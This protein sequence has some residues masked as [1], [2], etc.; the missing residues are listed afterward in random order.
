MPLA[1][2]LVGAA[3]LV[4][5]WAHGRML[6]LDEEMIA[7]NLRDRTVTTLT[8]RLSLGQAA[9]YGWLVAQ[10]AMLLA[11][12]S[13]ERALRFLPMAFGV[14]TL[15]AALWIGRR[16]MR[17]GGAA[18]LAFLCA[19]GQWIAF[20]ALELKHY[21]ADVCFALLLPALAVRVT[22]ASGVLE[23]RR[24][25]LTWWIVAAAAQWISNG[26]L[27]VTPL[28]AL[29][30]V[31]VAAQRFGRREAIRGAAAPVVLWLAS[32]SANYAVALGPAR[33][34]EF[35][36]GYW[37]WAFP[38]KDSGIAATLRWLA[39]Q[40]LPLAIKPG[41]SGFAAGFWIAAAAGFVFG[42]ARRS[43]VVFASAFALV[44]VAA[45]TWA[46]I[47]LVPMSE[48]L[49]LWMIP[50]MYVGIALAFD[51]AVLAVVPLADG[52][53]QRRRAIAIAG[54]AATAASVVFF[55][56]VYTRGMTYVAIGPP[57]ANHD[58]DDRGA[59]TWLARQQ[60]TG[61]VWITTRNALPAIWW[62]AHPTDHPILEASF[63]SGGASCGSHDVAAWL[64][65]NRQ[66]R[67][68]VYF[69]FGHDVPPEFDDALLAR[70][71]TAGQIVRYRRF[72][73]LGHA[74]VV[75][76]GRPS[77]GIATLAAL[78]GQEMTAGPKQTAG[79][80]RVEPARV[81]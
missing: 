74:L 32:F 46:G 40:V 79:C 42:R 24:R 73:G 26:A 21:S 22:E 4:V 35:L 10:R 47:R 48:R 77:A 52:A 66:S 49:T 13:G 7:I 71:S 78:S 8:G 51:L 12:G 6:W 53:R 60:R 5:Q 80:I 38:P 81:W 62:Y 63:D 61:D 29:V 43:P 75:D 34:S 57:P 45:F 41:G 64:T 67:A 76:V 37:S 30:L 44:P 3:L 17:V 58:L 28:S 33:T 59:V 65:S 1:I 14:A 54:A 11:A 68:L 16:W 9:P 19:F 72:G 20:H 18:A 70:L 50:A 55:A 15:A 36:Q 23:F 27:F 25:A 31:C 56:D 39:A 69:G 2:V